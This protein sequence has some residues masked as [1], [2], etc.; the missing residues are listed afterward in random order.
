M[1]QDI[2]CKMQSDVCM[3]PKENTQTYLDLLYIQ[4]WSEEFLS[5]FSVVW[6]TVDMDTARVCRGIALA[7]FDRV[8]CFI[9]CVYKL[10]AY[11]CTKYCC[12][13]WLLPTR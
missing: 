7:P 3:I 12:I 9:R 4:R 2:E 11:I 8:I 6:L 10:E 13:D 1:S 5:K